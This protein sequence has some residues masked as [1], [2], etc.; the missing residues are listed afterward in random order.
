MKNIQYNSMEQ[1]KHIAQVAP[2]PDKPEMQNAIQ[3][4]TIV[5]ATTS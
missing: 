5:L 4:Q 3:N 1:I 2:K